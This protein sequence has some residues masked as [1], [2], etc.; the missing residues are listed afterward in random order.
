MANVYCI[1][2][3]KR[4]LVL[5]VNGFGNL[6]GVIGS[7]LF[8]SSYAPRYLVP[9]YATLGFIAFALVGYVAYRILLRQ[10]NRHRMRK[11]CGWTPAELG[12]EQMDDTRIGDKKYTFMYSL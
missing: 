7:Q 3:N 1:D 8:R 5:G 10:V 6:A 11:I 2:P 9:F 12:T 4:S